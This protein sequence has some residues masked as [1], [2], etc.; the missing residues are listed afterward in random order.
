MTVLIY[1]FWLVLN[2]KITLEIAILGVPITAL[3]L[4]FLFKYCE[5][6]WKQEKGL[7]LCV[8]RLAAY[9]G[10]LIWE[11]V[12]ANGVML[13]VVYGGKADPVVCTIH[14][15][16]KSRMLRT[17]LANSISLTPGTVTLTCREDELTIHCLTP[18]MAQG[19][20]HTVFERKLKAIEEALRG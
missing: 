5:W 7:Y 6:S 17:L 8:P 4:I 12:K 13:R 11:I 3:A 2:G 19:L 1:G 9:L 18:Q 14:T 15:A 10:V 20:D 16:L